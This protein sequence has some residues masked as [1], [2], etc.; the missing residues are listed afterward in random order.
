MDTPI[1]NVNT[2][3]EETKIALIQQAIGF[4][5]I[6]IDDMNKKLDNMANN[7]ITRL[8]MDNAFQP[9]DSKI[10]DN[11]KAISTMQKELALQKVWSWFRTAIL[12]IATS[13]VTFLVINYLQHA[14]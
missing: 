11:E 3:G 12:M 7:Y 1:V 14:H 2:S 5:N 4:A 6:K 9:R 8:Q 10:Y 13:V